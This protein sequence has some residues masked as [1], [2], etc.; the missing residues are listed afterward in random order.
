[1]IKHG[2]KTLDLGDDLNRV[3]ANVEEALENI[4]KGITAATAPELVSFV[5]DGAPAAGPTT[6]PLPPIKD[7]G[8]AILR[9]AS[10][11]MR[12]VA[13]VEIVDTA[14]APDLATCVDRQIEFEQVISKIDQIQQRGTTDLRAR[15]M[16]IVLV[17]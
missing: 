1:M 15:R 9:R 7:V 10:V 8:G 4:A 3:Q 16:L 5:V 6:V 14:P 11:G 13:A 12:L 2:F 17:K